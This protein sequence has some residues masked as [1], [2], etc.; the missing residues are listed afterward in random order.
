MPKPLKKKARAITDPNQFARAIVEQTTAAIPASAL[1]AYMSALG[2]KGGKI[3]GARR[4][5]N[6]SD[7][8][9]SEIA[10]RAATARWDRERARKKRAK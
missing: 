9:R 1:S 3:S 6:L 10:L 2:S 7:S 4:M 5:R 8:K